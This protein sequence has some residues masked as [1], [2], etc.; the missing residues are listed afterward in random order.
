MRVGN[1][2]E[3]G[4]TAK[5]ATF[6]LHQ[7]LEGMLED[8]KI[9]LGRSIFSAMKAKSA[10]VSDSPV[11]R[12]KVNRNRHSNNYLSEELIADTECTKPVISEEIVKD[13]NLQV[14]PL[15]NSRTI[16]DASGR[17]LDITGT[18]KLFVSSQ[19]LRGT[20]E[21]GRRSCSKGEF[22]GQRNTNFTLAT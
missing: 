9:A 10:R 19:V 2:E 18:T 22:C 1:Q 8:E 14:K 5:R 21:T 20:Q 6:S 15:S 7:E 3:G 16:L 17:C 11:L 12:G 4:L 13:L